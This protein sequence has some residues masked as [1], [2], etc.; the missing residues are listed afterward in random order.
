M[1]NNVA[2]TLSI[3]FDLQLPYNQKDLS[4]D[5]MLAR[6]YNKKH[7]VACFEELDQKGFG[8]FDRG[9]RG[10]GYWAK[11]TPNETCPKSYTLTFEIK[12]RGKKKKTLS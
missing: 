8:V 4:L 9:A 2:L 5:L 10:R 1:N 12:K 6:Q 3:T 11:F 7:I